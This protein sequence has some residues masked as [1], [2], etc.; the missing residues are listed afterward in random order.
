MVRTSETLGV[1]S[2]ALIR[3]VEMFIYWDI[4]GNSTNAA[5][6]IFITELLSK[7]VCRAIEL[8]HQ[9]DNDFKEEEN[10][11]DCENK[12]ELRDHPSAH[13]AM[14]ARVLY[15]EY[16]SDTSAKREA[17]SLFS[18]IRDKMLCSYISDSSD[19]S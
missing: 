17:I 6:V 19:S 7:Q 10:L 3:S 15:S 14:Y 16:R 18:E 2:L 5:D 9:R 13:A 12:Q 4:D 11:F 1:N 8:L